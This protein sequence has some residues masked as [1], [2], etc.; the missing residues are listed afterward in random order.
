[1]PTSLGCELVIG[2]VHLN[3]MAE[4]P[5]PSNVREGVDPPDAPSANAE[6]RKAARALSSLDQKSDEDAA[7]KKEIDL[8]ALNDAMKTLG[9]AQE[10]KTPAANAEA[11]KREAPKKMIKVDQ[12]DVALL[13]SCGTVHV[14]E[15]DSILSPYDAGRTV[16]YFENN[17]YGP[18]QSSRRRCC[19]CHDS[20][21]HGDPVKRQF[22]VSLPFVTIVWVKRYSGEIQ[23]IKH[24][25]DTNWA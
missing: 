1:V 3:A 10:H 17:G 21:G 15:W 2:Q 25:H 23:P 22:E 18:T 11:A 7:P 4:E 5:Q 14:K 16:G 24:D 6:D 12:S 9:V 8:K 19:E 20:L 13:V